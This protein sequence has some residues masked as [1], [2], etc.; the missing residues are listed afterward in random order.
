MIVVSLI[1]SVQPG[2][3]AG[4][5]ISDGSFH[6]ISII[7]TTGFYI[8]DHQLW[9]NVII[10]IFFV[11]MFTGGTAGSTSGGL[12][13]L[14]LL[15]V[16]K[17]SQQELVRQL[18]LNAFIPVRLDQKVISQTTV[19][20]LLVFIS[21][22]F[23]ILCASALVLSFMNYDLV[24]SFSTSA[25]MLA[26]I[27]PGLGSFGPFTNFSDMPLFGKWFLSALMILGRLELLTVMVL[28]T[29]SFYKR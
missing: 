1:L 14:R 6:V 23:L 19:F 18:H 3:S 26:N 29:R 9:G 5:A 12:K 16:A 8:N 15:I 11:L 2:I 21:L 22:Y 28:F 13:I 24:T 20:N 4:K 17:N 10:I 25:S 7:T 27:G